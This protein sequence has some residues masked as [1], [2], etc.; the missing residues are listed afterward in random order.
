MKKIDSQSSNNPM[1]LLAQSSVIVFIGIV[2]SKILTYLYRVIIARELGP[3]IY[4]L[5]SLALVVS[6]FFVMAASLG[7]PDG[8]LRYLSFY[9]G[10]NQLKK[11]SYLF[12]SAFGVLLIS[13]IIAAALLYFTAEIISTSLFHNQGLTSFLKVFGIFLP[14]SIIGGFFLSSLLAFGHI[15][16]NA[17]INNFLQNFIKVLVLIGLLFFGLQQSAVIASYVAGIFVICL[18]AFF[19]V[20]HLTPTLLHKSGLKIAAK[21]AVLNEVFAYSWPIVF[22]AALYTVFNWTDSAVIG[23][24]MTASDVGVYNA[25]FTLISLFGI[26]PELFRQFFFPYIVREYSRKNNSL[27]RQMS[28]QVGKWIYVVNLPLFLFMAA[29]PGAVINILFGPEYLT[30]TDIL[31]ILAVGGLL[32]SFNTLLTNLLSMQGKSR[33][34][35]I[36]TIGIS[37]LDLILNIILVPHYGLYG[38][39]GST[40]F[41]LGLLGLIMLF[42]VRNSTGIVPFRRKMWS[43]TLAAAIPAIGL[44]MI[45]N[46]FAPSLPVLALAGITFV[47]IYFVF[48]FAF[49]SL[50]PYDKDILS[51]ALDK[52]KH[53]FRKK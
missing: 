10:K 7:L 9:R 24:F 37:I 11:S 13:S 5:F 30:A 28:Q 12:R 25:A 35:L 48:I 31:R 45:K 26:A 53:L 42:Q 27:I 38:A 40:T 44:L 6:S 14:F 3:E 46:L 18:A 2:L 21:R 16:W 34:I 49:S 17:L 52:L 4:G 20:R 51:Y 39:A 8:A 41:S 19:A 47:A 43:V 23:Y 22:L 50:D 15:G 29:F 32:A 1:R 36:N 33:I